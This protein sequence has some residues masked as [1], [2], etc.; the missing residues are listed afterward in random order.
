[1]SFVSLYI[2]T[3]AV[4]FINWTILAWGLNIQFGYAGIPNF[5]IYSFF[6]VGA[7]FTGVLGI[8]PPPPGYQYILGWNLP[9]P[10]T[11]LG[12]AVAS[13][14][15]GA[16]IG[17][18]VL[19]RFRQ[20]TYLAIVLFSFGFIA[21]DFVQTDV[22]VFNGFIGI[23]GVNEPLNNYLHLSYDAY[24]LFFIGLS[25]SIALVL[26][27][28]A[29]RLHKSQL[30]RAMRAVRNN[31]PAAEALGKNSFK[32]RL[33][34]MTIGC[35]YAGI[36]GGLAIE[37]ISAINPSGL[38]SPET[39]IVWT[40]LLLGGI[41]NN[42][43]AI[44]GSLLVPVL[45]LQGSTYIPVSPDKAV[46]AEALRFMAVGV[47][48]ILVLAV[49]PQGLIPERRRKFGETANRGKAAVMARF[50]DRKSVAS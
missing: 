48:L 30:G 19:R 22:S 4:Y 38:S 23:A 46:L 3:A 7:Y 21:Y 43:G 36:A 47:I 39:F 15:L 26:F 1:M 5:T 37:Y 10:L 41:G 28:F 18:L 25:G 2:T 14:I 50:A 29:Q 44:A 27:F 11:L 13:G 32:L 42:Y 31:L 16:L 20:E 49:R 34:A 35:I 24:G 33:I 45:L 6:G 40:A 8:G 17:V 12:G 9:F